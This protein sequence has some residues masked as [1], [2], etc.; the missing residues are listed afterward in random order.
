MYNISYK[1]R[2]YPNKNQIELLQ[3]HFDATRFIYNHFLE[4]KIKVY[5]ETK[6]TISWIKQSSELPSLKENN[7]WLKD[8]NSQSLQQSI[9]NLDRA[10]TAFFRSNND[11]PKF[12]TKKKSRKTFSVSITSNNIKLDI[13]HNR[14]CIPKFIKNNTIKCKFHREVKG[15]I[16]QATISQ[17]KD[18]KYYVSILTEINEMFKPKPKTDRET[19]IGLDFG[20]NTFITDSNGTKVESPKYFKQSSRKLAKHQQELTKLDKDTVRYKSKQ[21]QITKLYSKIA[22]QRK[23]FLDKL[24]YKLTHDNQ[25]NTICIEDLSI[26]KM[27][28]KGWRGLNRSI[29][30]QGW[31]TFTQMLQYKCDWYGRN[32]IKIGRFDPSSKTCNCCGVVK[33]DLKLS[34][35]VWTCKECNTEHDRDINAAKNILDFAFNKMNFVKGR[36]YPIEAYKLVL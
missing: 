18:S 28:E 36:N 12:K 35:R 11:F 2:L 9:I 1:F 19:G 29:S 27:Q 17:D 30:D 24:S 34:D 32:I 31:Y 16:K 8:V 33:H 25:M 15:K 13:E 4:Q 14:L 6:K 10:Y 22:R 21:E 20:L 7:V 23:D 5:K 26:N 3:K